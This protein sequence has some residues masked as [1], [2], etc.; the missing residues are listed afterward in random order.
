MHVLHVET[1]RQLFGGARQ[2]LALVE[3][4][5]ARH[6]RHSLVCARGTDVA[7][8]ARESGLRV[9][10]VPVAGD[11]DARLLWRFASLMQRLQPDL[12]HIHSR[13]GADSW[14]LLAASL[15]SR[16]VVLTRRVD[17]PEPLAF[18]KYRLASRIVAISAGVAG[19]LQR[20][21]VPADKVRIVSSA[22]AV[23]DCQASWSDADFRAQFGLSA[24]ARPIAVVAQFIPRKGHELLCDV[25]PR[26]RHEVPALQVLLFGTGQLETQ[27][28]KQFQRAGLR[29]VVRFAG[30]RP[31][32]RE[33]LG[34]FELLL[35]PAHREGLGI[36]L[37]EAQAAGVPVVGLR[38]PGIDEAID[39]GKTGLLVEASDA[40][41]LADAVIRVLQD[42]RLRRELGAAGRQRVERLFSIDRMLRGNLDVYREVLEARPDD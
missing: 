3:G 40:C 4:L 21:G 14:G 13:R 32:L 19:Q 15:V 31:D 11:A 17:N 22:V 18:W 37:L 29:D 25:L 35:H 38:V 9:V 33:F 16:P 6:G 10:D 42:A 34:C 8:A 28:R 27:L 23:E 30:F 7:R 1:G 36:A 24:A 5:G 12:V 20:D 2:A 26:V 39:D 41:G